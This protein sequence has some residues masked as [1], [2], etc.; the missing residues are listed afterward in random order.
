MA[1]DS[2]SLTEA[3][4]ALCAQV[5]PHKSGELIMEDGYTV[6]IEGDGFMEHYKIVGPGDG[7]WWHLHYDV[8][9]KQ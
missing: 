5:F 7:H 9:M 8:E 4:D 1:N 2:S 6:S 3:L